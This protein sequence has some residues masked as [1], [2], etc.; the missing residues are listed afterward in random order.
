MMS[1]AESKGIPLFWGGDWKTFVDM[2][3]Y[4]LQGSKDDLNILFQKLYNDQ[5]AGVFNLV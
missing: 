2:P 3:H 1:I 5:Y 4:Q